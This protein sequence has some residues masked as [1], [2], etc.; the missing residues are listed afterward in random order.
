MT[1][2]TTKPNCTTTYHR[3]GTVSV[4]NCIAQT[5]ERTGNPSDALLA[6]L[7][8]DDRVRVVLHTGERGAFL[9]MLTDALALDPVPW[10]A[11]DDN[12]ADIIDIAREAR[13]YGDEVQ[14]QRARAYMRRAGYGDV[15]SFFCTWA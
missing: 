5:W 12:G 9:N 1:T 10:K 2:P 7:D 4:W 13:A 15:S 3:D 14:Y 6:T 8:P 11:L